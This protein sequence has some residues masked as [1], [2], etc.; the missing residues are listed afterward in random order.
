MSQFSEVTAMLFLETFFSLRNIMSYGDNSIKKEMTIVNFNILGALNVNGSL[1]MKSISQ[2]LDIKKSN[3]TKTVDSLIEAGLVE[4]VVSE[5]DRRVTYI[6]LT[7]KGKDIYTKYRHIFMKSL[8][9]KFDFF[10]QDELKKLNDS[11]ITISV[12]I[13]KFKDNEDIGE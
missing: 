11:L 4:R 8:G 3:L 9:E 12:L 6:T 13:Q 7:E 10:S 2:M 1:P 5:K